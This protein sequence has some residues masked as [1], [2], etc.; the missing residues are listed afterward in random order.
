MLTPNSADGVVAYMLSKFMLEV[1]MTLLQVLEILLLFYFLLD[2][3]GNFFF[4]WMAAWS[5]SMAAS[6]AGLMLGCAAQDVKQATEVSLL[7][8]VP[9]MLFCGFF[10]RLQLVPIFLQWAQ[11]LCF[12]KYATNLVLMNEFRVGL[13]SCQ[14]SDQAR[15]NCSGVLD[16]NDVNPDLFYVYILL[17]LGICVFFRLIG[18]FFLLRRAKRFY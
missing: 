15:D 18:L 14:T 4:T 13:P 10:I 16:A 5:L 6:S 9:Q 12:Y 7:I 17:L 1:P 2:M 11:Y 3:Q 8:Y